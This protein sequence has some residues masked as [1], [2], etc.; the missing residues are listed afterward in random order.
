ML[1]IILG[2]VLDIHV[3]L[4][5]LKDV[6]PPFC[7]GE[8]WDLGYL[9]ISCTTRFKLSFDL[10]SFVFYPFTWMPSIWNTLIF[11]GV[12]QGQYGGKHSYNSVLE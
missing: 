2:A 7:R 10:S 5:T 3:Y 8:K 4:I 6:L 9:T 11:W 1:D 12:A